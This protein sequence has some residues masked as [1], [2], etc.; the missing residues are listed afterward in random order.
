MDTDVTSLE[1]VLG[2]VQSHREDN[3]SYICVSNVHMCMEVFDSKDFATVVNTADMVI[4]DGRPIYWAQKLLGNKGA[5][6]VRGQDIMNAICAISGS[7]QL[8]IGLYGGSS[9]EL[10]LEVKRKL[11]NTY[12]DVKITYA[13]APPFRSLTE[14]E[15][16]QMC[17]EINGSAV[18]VLFV[19]IG[20]PK[21]ERWMYEHKGKIN[22]VMLGVG[23]AFDFIAGSKKHAPRWMQLAGLEWLFRLA[24]EP[25]RLWQRYLKQNPRFL[26]HFF[27]QKIFGI[28]FG[29]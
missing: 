7:K 9:P 25:E 17:T 11:S 18:D 24:S 5:T 15:D 14:T 3:S 10:L 29:D 13:Y 4:P 21:Q 23:A 12:P 22:C 6:Q 1:E 27:R 16:V 19:G 8:N 28:E 2:F 26:F 20:C